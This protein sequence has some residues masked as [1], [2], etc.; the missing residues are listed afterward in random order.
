MATFQDNRD[1]D[2]KLF[3]HDRWSRILK[4]ITSNN[5]T[6]IESLSDSLNVSHATIR[7]DLNK[8]DEIQQLKRVR[9]GAIA[10]NN[11]QKEYH[12]L[13]GQADHS[14]SS[15]SN[16]AEKAA[17]G[18]KA[19]SLLENGEAVIIDGGTT[20]VQLAN[21][22]N[23]KNLN[24]LTT[25]ISI[26]NALFG[27][28]HLRI[29]I[30]GGEVFQE[31]KVILNP[32]GD[33]IIS[34]FSASKIFLGAQAITEKGLLQTDPLLVHYE[35]DLINRAEEVIV[36]ADS[37]KFEVKGS[38]IVCELDRIHK[39]VT[40]DNISNNALEMFERHEIDVITVSL[41]N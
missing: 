25:S 15:V 11:N 5:V 6:S 21:A 4:L 20:T 23:T 41:D 14:Q 34:K 16:A 10:L 2:D 36:L 39:I 1:E 9:G 18:K 31:Q 17:I 27:K 40:D 13:L 12:S 7:R 32:Y 26:M 37:T 29:M 38:L 3:I 30:T 8:L 35:Q 19:A 28:P 33:S 22:I 24:I